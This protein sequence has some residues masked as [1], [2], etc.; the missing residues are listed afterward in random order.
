MGSFSGRIQDKALLFV[1][2]RFLCLP[3]ENLIAVLVLRPSG[4][5]HTLPSNVIALR[6]AMLILYMVERAFFDIVIC[7][8]QNLMSIF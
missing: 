3:F 5:F 8:K 7:D 4:G 2:S 6:H 1:Q